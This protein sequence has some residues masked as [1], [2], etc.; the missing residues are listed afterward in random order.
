M[1]LMMNVVWMKIA[2]DGV[3]MARVVRVNVAMGI[4]L[5]SRWYAG[6]ICVRCVRMMMIA[7]LGRFAKETGG[8]CR[9]HSATLMTIVSMMMRALMMCVIQ[10]QGGAHTLHMIGSV[11]ATQVSSVRIWS[12]LIHASALG[13]TVGNAG[14]YERVMIAIQ[15]PPIYAM[16]MENANMKGV[17]I[18]Q[19]GRRYVT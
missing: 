14:W 19:I 16:S 17:A 18:Y 13:V 1:A 4:A 8:V 12:M 9:H 11:N 10:L 5:V 3:A 2:M 15:R 7:P 6:G